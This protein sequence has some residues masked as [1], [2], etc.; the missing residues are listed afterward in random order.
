MYLP[1]YHHNHTTLDFSSKRQT[2]KFTLRK[3]LAFSREKET[4]TKNKMKLKIDRVN[5]RLKYY[6]SL[7]KIFRKF[8]N[9]DDKAQYD[10]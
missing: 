3:K 7:F 4:T 2:V 6:S 1:L 5:S 9:R 10:V 8:V